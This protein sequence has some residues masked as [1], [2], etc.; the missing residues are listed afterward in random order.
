MIYSA[1]WEG[2]PPEIFTTRKESP[3]S[4]PLGIPDSEVLVDFVGGRAGGDVA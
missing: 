1:A 3:Q 4:Q 2:N